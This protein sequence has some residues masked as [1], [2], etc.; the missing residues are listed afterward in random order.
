MIS[1][2]EVLHYGR[3]LESEVKSSLPNF[4]HNN[5]CLALQATYLPESAGRRNIWD[6]FFFIYNQQVISVAFVPGAKGL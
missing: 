6:F 1:Y 2:H 5:S 3:G 4:A